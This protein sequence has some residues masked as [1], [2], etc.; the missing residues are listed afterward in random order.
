MASAAY[1]HVI[2]RFQRGQTIPWED[3]E[4]AF[5]IPRH[6]GRWSSAIVRLKERTLTERGIILHAEKMLGLRLLT[7]GESLQLQRRDLT[8][9]ARR[10]RRRVREVSLIPDGEMTAHEMH[11]RAKQA[12]AAESLARAIERERR[13]MAA[14]SR[15][16][17]VIPSIARSR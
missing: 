2:G 13:L 7:P 9:V 11:V 4:Q 15:P 8:T 12:E 5:G 6:T 14:T 16:T 3:I 1:D 17:P 10:L